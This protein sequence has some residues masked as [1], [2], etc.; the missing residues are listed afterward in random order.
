MKKNKKLFA[1]LTLVAFMMTLMPVMA[2]AAAPDAGTELEDATIA[3]TD[4]GTAEIVVKAKAGSVATDTYAIW[5]LNGAGDALGAS[6]TKAAA[7]IDSSTTGA[8][9]TFT[10]TISAP[11]TAQKY[12]VVISDSTAWTTS[13]TLAAIGA[14]NYKVVEVTP[15]MAAAS[16]ILAEGDAATQLVAYA[17]ATAAVKTLVDTADSGVLSGLLAAADAFVAFAQNPTSTNHMTFQS[18]RSNAGGG[19][20]DTNI[21]VLVANVGATVRGFDFSGITSGDIYAV[22][23]NSAA[24]AQAYLQNKGVILDMVAPVM[25]GAAVTNATTLVM[26]F[27]KPLVGVAASGDITVL[28][29]G[30]SRAATGNAAVSGPTVTYTFAANTFSVGDT[31]TVAFTGTSLTSASGVQVATFGATSVTNNVSNPGSGVAD[32]TTSVFGAQYVQGGNPNVNTSFNMYALFLDN[33]RNDVDNANQTLYVW[34]EDVANPGT[35]SSAFTLIGN[36]TDGV[37]ANPGAGFGPGSSALSTSVNVYTLTG[38]DNDERITG[39][40]SRSGEYNIYAAMGSTGSGATEAEAVRNTTKMQLGNSRIVVNDTTTDPKQHYTATYN[41]NVLRDGDVYEFIQIS[42]NNVSNNNI[43]VTFKND[44]NRLVGKT[45]TIDTSSANITA[46]KTTATTNSLGQIDFNLSGS[47][48]GTYYVYLSCDGF[49]VRLQVRVGNT[50]ATYINV[51]A[52]PDA[53]IALYGDKDDLDI[54]VDLTDVNSNVVTGT[55]PAGATAAYTSATTAANYKYVAFNSK[56]SGT[57]LKDSDLAITWDSLDENYQVT[58]NSKTFDKEGTYEIKIVLDNG[59][60]VTVPFEVK[61]FTTPVQLL[62]DYDQTSIELGGTSNVPTV[63]YVDANGTKQNAKNRT[64]LAG[65]GYAISNFNTDGQITIKN[66]E[67]YIGQT[68]TVTAVDSRYNLTATETL[69]VADEAQ[70]IRFD[71]TRAQ[72]NVNNRIGFTIVDSL[73]NVVS[74][75][76]NATVKDVN[77]VVTNIPEGAKVSAVTSGSYQNDLKSTGKATMALTSDKEGDVTVQVLVSVE[78]TSST[79]STGLAT[80]YYTGTATFNV[81]KQIGNGSAVV[82]TI[83]SATMVVNDTTVAIDAAAMIQ[84]NRTFVPVR[85]LM[86]AFGAT[87]DFDAATNKIT[88]VADGKNIELTLGS[89]VMTVGNEAVTMD[90]AAFATEDGR[91]MVPVRFI[92]EAAGFNVEAT[93][94]ADGSTASVVFTK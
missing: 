64:T 11:A 77:F 53:P 50:A 72:V 6:A 70:S 68:I 52:Q 71:S 2:F 59:N 80:K 46:D 25:T 78:T 41:G 79:S 28:V 17:N 60:F 1:I 84:D 81:S 43:V 61:Q 86:E 3:L 69:T 44:D 12:A 33:A 62:L 73:G 75:G 94:N 13:T 21:A 51:A 31:I 34:A 49:E 63:K 36:A 83:G 22:G 4:T 88:I 56:P 5:P 39:S 57:V 66:D 27:D 9:Q 67:R 38:V 14:A 58:L 92:A 85:A 29:N 93:Y 24:D 15:D 47:R 55:N 65:T 74:L 30:T 45:V 23:T 89:S 10:H 91:T 16:A 82:M 90:V 37:V 7:A 35:P 8:T 19:A 54:R 20:Q 48:E 26:T 40:F 87:V 32:V 42:A 76:N 18:A